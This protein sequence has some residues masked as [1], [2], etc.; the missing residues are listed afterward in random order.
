[1]SVCVHV[2]IYVYVLVHQVTF[3]FRV[4]PAYQ[5]NSTVVVE[6]E[7][8]FAQGSGG[9]SYVLGVM[10][11]ASG[12]YNWKVYTYMYADEGQKPET[13]VQ[14]LHIFLLALRTWFFMYVCMYN[15]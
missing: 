9:A 11:L 4:D 3:P 14:A 12:K 6:G 5:S 1:M 8:V 2:Y 10:A 15:T 13:A 7:G